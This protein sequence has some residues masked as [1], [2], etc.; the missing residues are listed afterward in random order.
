MWDKIIV[1]QFQQIYAIREDKVMDNTDKQCG[2]ISVL[3]DLTLAQVDELPMF[4]F[5]DFWR[6]AERMLNEESIPGKVR[7]T[8][9][10]G[11]KRFGIQYD[12]TKLRHRQYVEINAYAVKPIENIHLIMASIVQRVNLFGKWKINEADE[13]KEI[14]NRMLQARFIDV[15]H[16]CVFFCNLFQNLMKGMHP[17]I[18]KEMVAKGIPE[19]EAEALLTHSQS[20]LAGTIPQ[21]K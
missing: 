2:I 3:F 21:M 15:Y 12:I 9:A 7:K 10:V 8:F 4:A 17:M 6:I 18:I 13:H 1:Q 19:K 20:V 16:C 14:A 11:R 5:N